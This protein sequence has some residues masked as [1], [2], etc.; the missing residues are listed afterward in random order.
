MPV[1]IDKID[2]DIEIVPSSDG[3]P[4]SARAGVQAASAMV[5]STG[6]AKRALMRL[7]H[8]ELQEYLR[9]RG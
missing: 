5:P 4:R 7:L 3:P 8:E 2:S 1:H 9:I 6:D